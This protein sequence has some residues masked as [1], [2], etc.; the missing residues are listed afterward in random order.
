MKSTISHA[1]VLPN[2][3]FNEWLRAADAYIKAFERVAVV[4]SP[5]GNDLNRYRNV[6]AVQAPAVWVGNDA[7]SHIRRVYPMVVRVDVIRCATPSDLNAALQPRIQLKDRYGEK[8]TPGNIFDRFTLEW[9]SDARPARITRGFN[10]RSVPDGKPNEGIDLHAPPGTPIRAAASG[11]VASVVRQ[12]T[13]LGYGQYVQ[14]SSTVGGL[15]YLVTY[16][17]LTSIRV[18]MGQSVKLGDIIGSAEADGIKL[19]VQQPGRGLGGYILPDVVDPTMM[20]YWQ[21]LRLRI[22]VS[23]LRI[24]ERPGTEFRVIG[25][26]TPFDRSETLEPHGRTLQKVGRPG[27]WLKIR[28]PQTVEGYSA[29]E[30]LTADDSEGLSAL[31]MTGVNLDMLHPLGKPAAERLKGLGWVR[32]A[33]SVSMDRGSTDLDAAYNFYAPFIDRYAKAGLKVILVLTHQT[34]GEGQGYVWPNMDLGRWRELTARFSD[35]ARRIAQRFVGRSQIAAYQIWNE[36]DTAPQNAHAAVPIPAPVYGGLLTDSIR[37]IRS[38]DPTTYIITGGHVG[39]PGLGAAYAREALAAM[40]SGIRPDAIACHSYG[41][42]PVGNKYSPFGS[43][44]EDV[45]AYSKVLPGA[46]V[47]ITEWGVLDRPD[48]P[49]GEVADY[50]V[51]FV[52]RLKTLYSSRVA[53]AVWYGWADT[54]HNGYGLVNR[55]DQPKQ[56]L[57]DRFLQV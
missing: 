42:G 44:D 46:P 10:D 25:Q 32:F 37:A 23:G 33:Y 28:S 51:A 45:D 26:L 18:S 29:A 49:A 55:S 57:Y 39:G 2:Q 4:R 8:I 11:V 56:P 13:A 24:R 53:A 40:P 47:W 7:L 20:I 43:I 48:D 17:R 19:V 31:N 54:M 38:V 6:T 16:A 12:P 27:E 1:L 41:R 5:A 35:F 34:Y 36:Q 9:P 22:N 14:I 52:R 21:D 3:D 15:T 50:A 30:Y